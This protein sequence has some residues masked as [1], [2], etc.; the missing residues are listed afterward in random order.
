VIETGERIVDQEE[1]HRKPDGSELWVTT[2]KV[3]WRDEDGEIRGLLGFTLDITDRKRYKRRLER[4]NERLDEFASVV[5]HD[6][7]NPL[8]VITASVDL[9]RETGDTS[10]L[11]SAVRAAE[12]IEELIESLLGLA[13][14]GTLAD[15]PDLVPL[16]AAA[17]E[18]WHHAR[19]GDAQLDVRVPDGVS[20][21]ADSQRLLQA[22]ENLFRNAVDHNDESVSVWVGLLETGS[23]SPTET[24]LR[25]AVTT[26]ETGPD[27]ERTTDETGP[28][29]ER[30]TDETGPDL[31][32]TTDETETETVA[33]GFYVADDG[34]GLPPERRDRV[35]DH[36]FTTDEDGTGFGLSIVAD[37]ALAHGWD[38]R[39]VESEH[40]GARFEF[41]TDDQLDR[42]VASDE[43]SR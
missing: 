15:D 14:A 2:T 5:S 30:T 22:F 41:R 36:G 16:G 17:T 18:A 3:P 13:R 7:R 25:P 12:R 21:A 35:F 23:N 43:C 19:T 33:T 28:D 37:I 34:S 31:E 9:A 32:R 39:A 20:V 8:N 27:L 11:D 6:L 10:H 1:H 24:E 29:L 38:V 42:S 40:G 26:D 4:Q